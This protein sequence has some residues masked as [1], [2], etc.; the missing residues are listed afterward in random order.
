MDNAIVAT[1]LSFAVAV[2]TSLFKT[3][4]LS[5]KQKQLIATGLSLI[6]GTATVIIGGVDL[7]AGNITPTAV[8]IYG[9]SQIAYQFVL[10]GTKL[11]TV[12]TN[13]NLF[14]GNAD[15]VEEVLQAADAVEKV[16]AKPKKAT[17]KKTTAKKPAT[18]TT[19]VNKS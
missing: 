7:S 3:V 18:R 2:L 17:P 10:K 11:D 15:K 19:K 13:T 6:A 4:S 14:G 5:T 12:I 16:V 8:A 1:G 9:A